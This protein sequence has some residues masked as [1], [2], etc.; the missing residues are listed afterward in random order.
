MAPAI[1]SANNTTF[2]EAG[3]R[4]VHGDLYRGPTA[5]LSET[6]GLPGGV[7]FTDN[8]DGTATLAGT[9]ATGSNGTYPLTITASNGVARRPPSPSP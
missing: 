6:G 1:T 4:F 9:P 8:G 2:T 3:G 7:T 5:T